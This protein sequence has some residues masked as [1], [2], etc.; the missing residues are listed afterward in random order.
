MNLLCCSFQ[1]VFQLHHRHLSR[2]FTINNQTYQ[3]WFK[4]AHQVVYPRNPLDFPKRNGTNDAVAATSSKQDPSSRKLDWPSSTLHVSSLAQTRRSRPVTLYVPECVE[5]STTAD[6]WISA[7]G[8][9]GSGS[10]Q[11]TA[12]RPHPANRHSSQ[13]TSQ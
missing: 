2:V 10:D 11:V 13:V 12:K 3:V 1:Y 8:R 6:S 5:E 9:S 7:S 4:C